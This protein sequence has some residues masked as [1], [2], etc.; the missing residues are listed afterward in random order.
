M[1]EPREVLSFTGVTGERNKYAKQTPWNLLCKAPNH[2]LYIKNSH[3]SEEN[4]RRCFGARVIA[5]K[6]YVSV[7]LI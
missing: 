5:T 7:R 2:R 6:L 3:Q 4:G 1:T